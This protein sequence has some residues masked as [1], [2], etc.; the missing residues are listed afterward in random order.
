MY[1]GT[2]E[3]F[4]EGECSLP[5]LEFETTAMWMDLPLSVKQN[6]DAGMYKMSQYIDKLH[7]YLLM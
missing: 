4:E 7:V 6:M 2:G 5:N 1:L 3:V